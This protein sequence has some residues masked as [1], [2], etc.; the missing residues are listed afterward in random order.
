MPKN[1][2]SYIGSQ[3]R[4]FT[5]F[6]VTI[7]VCL[8]MLLRREIIY[9]GSFPLWCVNHKMRAQKNLKTTPKE[10]AVAK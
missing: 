3:Y 2:H 1:T 9:G 6:V 5:G 7:R 8:L 4:T 10:S